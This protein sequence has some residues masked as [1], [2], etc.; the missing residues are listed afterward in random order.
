MGLTSSKVFGF[1]RWILRVPTFL[2]LCTLLFAPVGCQKVQR[3]SDP[4]LKPI[5]DMLD[6][7]VPV[8]TPEANVVTFLNNRGYPVLPAGKQGT[9]VTAIRHIDTQTVTPVT[10]QVTFYFDANHKLNTYEMQ[11]TFNEPVPKAEEDQET[12]PST[13]QPVQPAQQ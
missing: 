12:S 8:G 11:R 13:P 10:A 9:I 2:V 6:A 7:H 3:M 5:Q 4:Q 1:A